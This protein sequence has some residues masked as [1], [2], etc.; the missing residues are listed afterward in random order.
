M[1]ESQLDTVLY[2]FYGLNVRQPWM[3]VWMAGC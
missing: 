3:K 2:T 1:A